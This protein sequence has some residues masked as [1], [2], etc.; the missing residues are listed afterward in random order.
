M[1]RGGSRPLSG[2]ATSLAGIAASFPRRAGVRGRGWCLA[3][4]G[5]RG[6]P[7]FSSWNSVD[8]PYVKA[9]ACHR[10]PIIDT[11]DRAG[12]SPPLAHADGGRDSATGSCR[13]WPADLPLAS[14]A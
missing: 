1:A 6:Q 11:H 12:P 2:R 7:T 9:T 14:R 8:S 3:E 13:S 5:V 10:G 4:L